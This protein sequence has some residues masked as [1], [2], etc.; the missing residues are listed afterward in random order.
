MDARTAGATID[1]QDLG[2]QEQ[3]ILKRIEEE[4]TRLMSM[5]ENLHVGDLATLEDMRYHL[6]LLQTEQESLRSYLARQRRQ[7]VFYGS[8]DKLLY[9]TLQQPVAQAIDMVR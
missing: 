8:F 3:Q 5:V 2:E 9:D 7:L 6:H 1:V 4:I